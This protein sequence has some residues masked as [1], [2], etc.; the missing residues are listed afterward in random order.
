MVI[1]EPVLLGARAL[2]LQAAGRRLGL[3]DDRPRLRPFKSTLVQPERI[4]ANAQP[5]GDEHEQDH[6]DQ[7]QGASAHRRQGADHSPCRAQG[8]T[9]RS[10]SK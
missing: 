6:R 10:S 4:P 9:L 7:Q 8:N 3:G 1:V 5:P 2:D